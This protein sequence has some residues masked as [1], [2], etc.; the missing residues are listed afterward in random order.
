MNPSTDSRILLIRASATQ[1]TAPSDA[2][3]REGRGAD[4]PNQAWF[5]PVT[6]QEHGPACV[7]CAPRNAAGIAI[8]TLLF[9]S[10]R[11]QAPAFQRLLVITTT[12]AGAAAVDHALATDPLVK[13]RFRET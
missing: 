1:P 10:A 7:C 2:I 5:Q 9:A 4:A 6:T 8:A 12:Q 3:L 11:G 13:A